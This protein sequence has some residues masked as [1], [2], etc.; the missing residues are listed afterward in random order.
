M[1]QHV[2]IAKEEKVDVSKKIKYF[3]ISNNMK[4][5]LFAKVSNKTEEILAD[6]CDL[7]TLV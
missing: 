1:L 7:H 4:V 5:T 3:N 6:Y 2:C